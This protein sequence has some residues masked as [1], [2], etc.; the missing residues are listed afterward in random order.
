MPVL[1]RVSSFEGTIKIYK[2]QQP[3]LLFL[4]VLNQLLHQQ[5]AI[6]FLQLFRTSFNIIWKKI[7]ITNFPFL[8]IHPTQVQAHVNAHVRWRTKREEI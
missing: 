1:H 2:M 8:R 3:V 5:V 6:T 7:F 4:V